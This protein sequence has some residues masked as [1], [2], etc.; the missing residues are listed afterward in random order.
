MKIDEI[1]CV[2]SS[3]TQGGGLHPKRN[4]EIVKYFSSKYKESISDETHSWPKLIENI[5]GIKTRNLGKC[6]TGV[7]YIVRNIEEILE[8]DISNK[9]FV[10]ERSIWGRSEVWDVQLK[11]WIVR[12]WG[13]HDGKNETNGFAS[14][15]TYDYNFEYENSDEVFWDYKQHNGITNLYLDTFM[16]ESNELIR[17]D[18]LF[19]NL[20]YRLSYLKI[21]Y[22]ILKSEQ[23]YLHG[24]E[25]IDIIKD[26]T[27]SL[28]DGS[29]LWDY[30]SKKEISIFH[31]SNGEYD[32]GHA[33]VEGHK[34][35]AEL[36]L[37]E[38]NG[39]I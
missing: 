12:N 14:Y 19:L 32:D 39:R 4:K 18:R 8:E 28:E 26:N 25:D 34:H 2:G 33:G 22:I 13:H 6:G 27:L 7:E 35:L 24:M 31:E 17:L 15:H 38:I 9:F 21:P 30:L 16:S 36:I 23:Y 1:I 11:E 5:S 37:K 10:I 3:H 20:C 29:D